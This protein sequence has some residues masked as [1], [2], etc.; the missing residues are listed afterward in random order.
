[1]WV[2]PMH[3]AQYQIEGVRCV[4]HAVHD[5]QGDTLEALKLLISLALP[6]QLLQ[7][8]TVVLIRL[9]TCTLDHDVKNTPSISESWQY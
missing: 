9:Q 3:A 6:L 7:P 4:A 5:G 1:M 2:V 8:T